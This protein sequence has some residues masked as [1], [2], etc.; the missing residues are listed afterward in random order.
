M[1]GGFL[2]ALPNVREFLSTEPVDHPRDIES[3]VLFGFGISLQAAEVTA[4][5]GGTEAGSLPGLGLVLEG[6]GSFTY[7]DRVSLSIVGAWGFNGYMLNLDT[8]YQS[9]YHSSKRAEAR[10]AW[11]SLSRQGHP[12]QWRFGLAAGGTFQQADERTEVIGPFQA[13]I[14]APELTRPYLAPEIGFIGS[15]GKDRVEVSLRYV[16][17]LDDGPAWTS[18]ASNGGVHASYAGSDDH[19]ALMTR[20]H[21]G[22]RRERPGPGPIDLPEIEHTQDTLTALHCKR[23]RITVQLWDDAEMDGDTVS[24]LLNGRPVLVAHQLDH[25]PVKLRLD[26]RYGTN[27]IEVI[28]HN[29]GRIAPNTARGIVRRGKGREDMKIK[30]YTTRSQLLMIERGKRTKA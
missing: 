5:S 25:D 10:L 24:V 1:G 4:D 17:H 7:R 9:L 16:L 3:R 30:T 28:A 23:E 15:T 18:D 29:E 13:L 22:C 2:D 27:T 11:H 8:I 6:G 12:R 20:Y 19:L 14:A 21:I 26:L